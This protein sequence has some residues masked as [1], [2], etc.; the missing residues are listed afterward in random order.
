ME[1]NIKNYKLYASAGLEGNPIQGA[2]P[3]PI[4]RRCWS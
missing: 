4:Y 2:F 1:E 3:Q